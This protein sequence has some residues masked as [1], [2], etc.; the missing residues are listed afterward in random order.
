MSRTMINDG[1]PRQEGQGFLPLVGRHIIEEA[2]ICGRTKAKVAP[3]MFLCCFSEDMCRRMPENLLACERCES[4]ELS[5]SRWHHTPSGCSKSSS[6]SE[7][8]FSSGRSKSHS[9]P[10]TLA[11]TILSERDLEI[12]V[13]TSIGDVCQLVPLRCAPSGIVIEISWQG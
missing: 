1:G 4:T 9:T 11:M 13:A 12:C 7:H 5:G 2:F 6:S 8:D 3:I 10:S